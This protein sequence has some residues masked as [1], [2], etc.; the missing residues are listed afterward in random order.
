[1][2]SIKGPRLNTTQHE[3]HNQVY[4]ADKRLAI[5]IG[6]YMPKLKVLFHS[7]PEFLFSGEVRPVVVELSN[8]SPNVP[9]SNI[10]LASNDPL[11]LAIDLPRIESSSIRNDQLALYRWD[12]SKKSTTMWLKGTENVGLTSLDLMFLYT[13]PGISTKYFN[14]VFWSF[15]NQK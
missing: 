10:I 3:R 5:Q 11:H 8:V 14:V 6:P 15:G 13:N 9:I 12:S 1:M 7:L 2:F 4:A